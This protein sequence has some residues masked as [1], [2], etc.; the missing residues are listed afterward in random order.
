MNSRDIMERTWGSCLDWLDMN[1]EEV[2]FSAYGA[3]DE[4]NGSTTNRNGG[5]RRKDGL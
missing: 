5:G 2:A 1:I 4:D 3:H